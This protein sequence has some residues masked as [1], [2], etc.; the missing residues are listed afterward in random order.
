MRITRGKVVGGQIVVEGDPLSEGASVTI[1]MADE[2]TFRLSDD[3]E[4]LLLESIE[5]ANRGELVDA[6]D[7]LKDLG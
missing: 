6:E 7:V 4:K 1:L 2:R 5:E 3:E